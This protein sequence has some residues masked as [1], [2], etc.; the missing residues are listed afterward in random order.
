[1]KDIIKKELE[2][3]FRDNM[4]AAEQFEEGSYPYIMFVSAAKGRL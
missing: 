1:M 2:R 3:R 4:K